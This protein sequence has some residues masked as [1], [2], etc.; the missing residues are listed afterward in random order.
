MIAPFEEWTWRLPPAEW[1]KW[2]QEPEPEP[3]PAPPVSDVDRAR[4]FVVFARHYLE[5]IYPHTQPRPEEMNPELRVFA[6]PGEFEPLTFIVHPLRDL[7][8]AKVTVSDL[9][10][11]KASDIDVRHV[12]F[13]RARP[14]YTV[15]GRYRIVPD[16][17]ERFDSL[18]LPAGENARFWLTVRVPDDAPP[19]LYRGGVTFTCAGGS[20]TLPVSLRILPFRLRED[21]EK[22]FGI[23]YRHPYDLMRGAPDEVSREYFRRK[24]ELEHADMVAHGTRNVVLSVCSPPA[25]AQGKF[26]FNW[27]LLAD[28]IEL[29]RRHRLHRPDRD[30]LQ[31]RGR[32]REVHE[33][34][35][36]LAP[37][38]RQGPAAGVQP[39][40]DGDGERHRDRTPGARLAGVSVL[41]R[42]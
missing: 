17:L 8:G 3:G 22:I 27:D 38:R 29:W 30:G 36:R 10:P 19:G 21:P 4:G 26:R 28:K 25:D 1:A 24:A 7:A 9:G 41:S 16:M 23:Y 35:P 33:G 13:L 6:T 20:A 14:N 31:H 18:D 37:A 42:R 32:L 5:C 34:A 2:K 11:V 39:R 40:A 12:R 15:T